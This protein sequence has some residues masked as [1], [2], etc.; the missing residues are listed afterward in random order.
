MVIIPLLLFSFCQLK[1]N[2]LGLWG[3]DSTVINCV[4]SLVFTV[5]GTFSFYLT[6]TYCQLVTHGVDIILLLCSFYILDIFYI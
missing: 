3:S 4:H 6:V 2:L 1:V 5:H